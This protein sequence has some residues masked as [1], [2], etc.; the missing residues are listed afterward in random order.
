MTPP[1]KKEIKINPFRKSIIQKPEN[2]LMHEYIEP[3]LP[4]P[5]V[6]L[7]GLRIVTM[8]SHTN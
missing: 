8:I 1:Q 5:K 7:P 6:E 4:N 3:N 2:V